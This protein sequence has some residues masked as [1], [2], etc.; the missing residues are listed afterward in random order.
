MANHASAKK[1]HIQ[2]LKRNQRNRP[3]RASVRNSVRRFWK[4]AE[5]SD[6]EL[7]SRLQEAERLLR[8]AGSKGIM[9]SRTV[10]RTVSR[11]ARA[12]RGAK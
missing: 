5:E 8:K 3:L 11:L 2:S 6:P 9:H 10:S 12:V 1:R 7:A 4:A